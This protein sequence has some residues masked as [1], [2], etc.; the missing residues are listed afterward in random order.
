[1]VMNSQS[2]PGRYRASDSVIAE[3]LDGETILLSMASGIYFGL[4]VIGTSIWRKLTA[5]G[6]LETVIEQLAARYQDMPSGTIERDAH[7]LVAELTKHGL[8]SPVG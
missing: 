1:M 8:L 3:E 2:M 6:D 7:D 5:G 4:N